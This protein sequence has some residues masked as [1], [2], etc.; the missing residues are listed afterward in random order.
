M[1]VRVAL[2]EDSGLAELYLERN[3]RRGLVGN[4]YKG[5]VTRVLPGMQAAF[6]DIGLEKAGF[7][8]VSDFYSDLA[9]Y[10]AVAEVTGEED[11]E[12]EA[13]A[14]GETE[15][16]EFLRVGHDLPEIPDD[17]EIDSSNDFL[18]N[19]AGDAQIDAGA[20]ADGAE[21]AERSTEGDIGG[22]EAA[23]SASKP[24]SRSRRG[25]GRRRRRHER[26]VRVPIEQQLKRGQEIIVQ[27]A[28]EPLGT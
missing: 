3:A 15:F 14:S 19:P 11:V 26:R 20:I 18:P 4:I 24:R 12:T 1:E 10:G 13:E 22:T 25:R 7:L 6:V 28:K 21:A 8:H 17:D 2:L 23:A 27:I 5:R 9:S 16:D